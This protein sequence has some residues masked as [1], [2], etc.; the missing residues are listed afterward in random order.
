MLILYTIQNFDVL[1]LSIPINYCNGW[2]GLLA[3]T[4]AE[5][6]RLKHALRLLS[7]AEK[8][9]RVSSERST[10]FTATLLQLGSPSPD[11]TQSG[12][13]RRQSSKTTEDDPSSA[14]RDATVA[15]RQ[16][17]DAHHMPQKLFSPVSVSKSAEKF[18]NHQR[19]LLALVDGF[20]FNAKPMHSRFRNSGASASS[21]DDGMMENMLF[22][23]IN[24]DKLDDI[25][26]RCIQRCHSKTL[27]QLLRAHGKLVSLSEGE[28]KLIRFYFSYFS[29]IE[30]KKQN[31][32]IKSFYTFLS[33]YTSGESC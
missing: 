33:H 24:T 17:P 18:S 6:D 10:W 26:E 7:E 1:V 28:G 4:E 2:F 31:M 21:H 29:L 13:S 3:V 25:W 8:Q 5:M 9:L 32:E 15:H 27:R 30:L 22:R 23:C 12:S 16:K 19:D 14:S 20:N 11:C